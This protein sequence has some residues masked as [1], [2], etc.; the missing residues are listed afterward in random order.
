MP[1]GTPYQGWP[2][3]ETWLVNLHLGNTEWMDSECRRMADR[4]RESAVDASQVK[5][6]IWTVDECILFNLSDAIKQWMT[7]GVAWMEHEDSRI[8]RNRQ[9]GD[10]WPMFMADL[11]KSAL[12]EVDWQ[13][14]AGH[15]LERD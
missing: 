2:S 8:A 4:C 6:K 14:I 5:E 10:F 12:D 13:K 7:D 15:Y 3:Y 9:G 1:K 11:M